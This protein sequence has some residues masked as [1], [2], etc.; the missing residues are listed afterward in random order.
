MGLSSMRLLSLDL[1]NLGLFFS[2][3]FL[4]RIVV[5]SFGVVVSYF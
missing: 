1:G 5:L 3:F 4:T 2:F